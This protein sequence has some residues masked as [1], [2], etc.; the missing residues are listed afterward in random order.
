MG[1]L[2]KRLFYLIMVALWLAGQGVLAQDN[3]FEVADQA[4][5]AYE[6]GD[7]T[8]AINLY[9]ALIG[10]GV[11][12]SRI[13]F[14]LGNAYY[15]SRNLGQ[16]LLNYRRAQEINPRDSDTST[17]LSRI[18][19][20]RVDLQGD[21]INLLESVAS[22]TNGV[23]TINELSIL[24]FVLWIGVCVTLIVYT[25]R[26]DLRSNLRGLFVLVASLFVISGVLLGCRL[27]TDDD[28]HPAVIV[29]SNVAIMS[30]P[31]TEYVEIYRLYNA[32]E[33]RV[34]EKRDGW[35]RFI[36]PDDRLGWL[37]ELAIAE[38]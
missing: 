13:F 34:L 17:S 29:E 23:V 10:S 35:V 31:G 6:A 5:A 21:E 32:A 11:N 15:Q 19:A 20:Q 37:P 25:L 12:D 2:V 1:K 33:M 7:F 36:L 38:V 18:R 27:Y 28:R 24:T 16:A 30:G 14:N 22:F 9:E 8:N 3:G 4:Q 26:L